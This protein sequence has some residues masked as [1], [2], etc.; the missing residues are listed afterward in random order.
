MA[1]RRKHDAERT[2]ADTRRDA[3]TAGT[4]RRS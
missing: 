3:T 1:R 4:R 2:T